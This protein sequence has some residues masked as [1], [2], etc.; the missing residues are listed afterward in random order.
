MNTKFPVLSFV[1]SLLRFIGWIAVLAGIA[2]IGYQV[3]EL[4][5]HGHKITITPPELIM[6]FGSGMAAIVAGLIIA[7]IGESIGVLF[8]IE[9]NTR[10]IVTEIH[11]E[12]TE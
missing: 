6:K 8:A 5:Q 2:Y 10:K 7:A 11:H 3:V 9:K 12:N 1:S 4:N